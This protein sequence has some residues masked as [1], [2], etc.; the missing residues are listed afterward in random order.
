MNEGSLSEVDAAAIAAFLISLIKYLHKNEVII[1]NLRPET[2]FFEDKEGFD[3]KIIDL[4]LA[5]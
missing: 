2:I 1:R 3:I 5:I 4:T